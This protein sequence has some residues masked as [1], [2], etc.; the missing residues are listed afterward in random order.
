M[1][2]EAPRDQ[3][4]TARVRAPFHMTEGPVM[5]MNKT[6]TPRCEMW[7]SVLC[8][9]DDPISRELVEALLTA[10]PQ[11]DLRLAAD[12]RSGIRAALASMPD[13]ILLDMHLPDISGLEVVRALSQH[14]AEGRCQ[15]ILLTVDKLTIDIVKAMSLGAREYWIKPLS[16]DRLQGDLPRVLRTRRAE[17]IDAAESSLRPGSRWISVSSGAP[18]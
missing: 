12:G 11:V 13:V 6:G 14:M 17:Q 15:V 10:F 2:Q 18:H 8:I 1:T 5:D 16:L 4:G 7:G 3:H 9:E